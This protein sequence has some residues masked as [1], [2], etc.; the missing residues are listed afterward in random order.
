[1]AKLC[2]FG[3]PVAKAKLICQKR[4]APV[5]G[6]KCLHVPVYGKIFIQVAEISV[7]ETKILVTRLS[8]LFLLI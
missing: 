2:H 8:F 4:F 6:L 1:M 3:H 7:V 5:A